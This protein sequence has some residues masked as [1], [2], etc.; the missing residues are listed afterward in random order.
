[1]KKI[2]INIIILVVILPIILVVLVIIPIIPLS[3]SYYSWD[4]DGSSWYISEK[5]GVEASILEYDAF[6]GAP[7]IAIS[8]SLFMD[9]QGKIIYPKYIIVNDIT[10]K[11]NNNYIADKSSIYNIIYV[12]KYFDEDEMKLFHESG[13]IEH[14]FMD[15]NDTHHII[16]DQRMIAGQGA[17][18]FNFK[19]LSFKKRGNIIISMN[20]EYVDHDNETFERELTLHYKRKY[21]SS[22]RISIIGY[23]ILMLF[24]KW[25]A[26]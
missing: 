10:I 8:I 12:G 3:G 6:S 9:N 11:Q 14:K 20:Y 1:M 23:V 15:W 26:G 7:F 16:V 21:Y 17:L 18:Y 2:Y 19:N 22:T 13:Y 25:L 4:L 24:A 5:T